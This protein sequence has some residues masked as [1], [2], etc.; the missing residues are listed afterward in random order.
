VQ[1]IEQPPQ[2]HALRLA[3]LLLVDISKI[4]SSQVGTARLDRCCRRWFPHTDPKA[5]W[6]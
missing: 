4:H 5:R 6:P 3:A 1:A 2:T